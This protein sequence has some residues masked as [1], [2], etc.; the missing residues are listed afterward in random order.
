VK[1]DFFPKGAIA[2]FV[3]MVAFYLA[4]WFVLYAVMVGR[5]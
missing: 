4:F 2:S 3:A 1:K 5:G